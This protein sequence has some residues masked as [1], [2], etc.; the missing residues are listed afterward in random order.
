[1]ERGCNCQAH[2]S[3]RI[4]SKTMAMTAVNVRMRVRFA[5]IIASA[6]RNGAKRTIEPAKDLHTIT[7]DQSP[8][9]ALQRYPRNF[10]TQITRS[11]EAANRFTAPRM[12]RHLGWGFVSSRSKK[13]AHAKASRKGGEN[14]Q[15]QPTI[16]N[17]HEA[18]MMIEHANR[19]ARCDWEQAEPQETYR[20]WRKVV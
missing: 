8:A 6:R 12:R 18:S 4:T 19:F 1:M 15:K 10:T 11:D 16:V 20:Y 5:P 3:T 13:R 9:S 2:M 14:I 17:N 7:H